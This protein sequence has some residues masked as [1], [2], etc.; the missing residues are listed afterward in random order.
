MSS[1][2]KLCRN[3]HRRV[4]NKLNLKLFSINLR[5]NLKKRSSNNDKKYSYKKNAR[6]NCFDYKK[7][8][9]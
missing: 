8:Q 9:N 7:F 5:K 2:Q 4:K 1:Y 3:V 6:I